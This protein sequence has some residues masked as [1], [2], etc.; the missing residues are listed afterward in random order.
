MVFSEQQLEKFLSGIVSLITGTKCTNTLGS[1]YKFHIVL[2]V[3][4]PV[5]CFQFDYYCMD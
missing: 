1:M 4:P 5:L 3:S 2:E